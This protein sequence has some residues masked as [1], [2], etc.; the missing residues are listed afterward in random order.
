L[1]PRIF[2]AGA[3]LLILFCSS[4]RTD[5]VSTKSIGA[6][7]LFEVVQHPL[8]EG[9]SGPGAIVPG[10]AGKIWFVEQG[11]NQ[12]GSFDP[13]TQSFEEYQIPTDRALPQSLSVDGSGNVWFTELTPSA[14][15]ELRHGDNQVREVS[16]P[17]STGGIPCGPIGVTPSDGG[18]VWVTC[19]FSN[20]ID[21]YLPS[22]GAFDQFNLPVPYSAPLQILFDKTGNFW[23]TAADSGMLGYAVTSQL[24]DGTSDGIQEF[25][26]INST[27]RLTITN[28]LLPSGQVTTSL[29]TPS[30]IAFS[31]GGDSLW[32]TEHGGGSFDRYD[33]GP[34]TLIKY[35][36]SR[37][38][39]D[40]YPQ[41]LPNGIAVD[42]SGSVWLTEHYGNRIAVFDPSTERLTEYP[43][44]CCGSHLAEALYLTIGPGGGVWFTEHYG[45]ALGELR[46]VPGSAPPSITLAP[47]T[48][49][50][51]SSGNATS[52][53][54]VYSPGGSFVVADASAFTVA[55]VTRGGRLQN[56]TASFEPI[57]LS[58]P[59][60][61]ARLSLQTNG[62]KPGTYYLT[63]AATVST[64]GIISAATLKLTV[65]S[66]PQPTWLAVL[67][68]AAAAALVSAILLFRRLRSN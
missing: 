51:G 39:S 9:A 21:E 13:S 31:L 55:G 50:I 5:P 7:S 26:P 58:G 32:I 2:A 56:V 3:L 29:A 38:V 47:Q 1:N 48:L 36:T 61:S 30:Q 17:A 16:I 46:P 57:N 63:V 67:G 15:G 20:Q 6:T 52:Q 8:P 40:S 10:G 43:I 33:I 60:A 35:F 19:E 42:P 41:S 14:L 24:R 22:T 45:N 28:Q 53:V 66:G 44:P 23:F 25:A 11:S 59:I 27:Y 64:G 4:V 62:L 18:A 65:A 37:P 54:D 34:R 12:L 68:V 49:T